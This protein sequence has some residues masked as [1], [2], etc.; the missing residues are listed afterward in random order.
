MYIMKAR[1]I[2]CVL[3]SKFFTFCLV[4]VPETWVNSLKPDETIA[5]EKVNHDLTLART[6]DLLCV[7]QSDNQLRHQALTLTVV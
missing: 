5:G 7:K 1:L 6:G 2:I 3:A 4:A